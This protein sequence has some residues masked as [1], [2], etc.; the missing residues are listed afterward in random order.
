M[1]PCGQGAPSAPGCNLSK[2]EIK[3]AKEAFA[4]GMKEQKAKRLDEAFQSF[5]TAAQMAPRN[6]EYV[7]S[8]EI[9]R[10][11]LVFDDLQRGNAAML[12][13]N[14]MEALADFRGATLLDPQ[15]EFA[16][17]RVRDALGD[18]AP[19]TTAPP[20]ILRAAGELYVAPDPVR[21]DFHY[22]GDSRDLLEQ[23]AK[24]FGITP[25]LDDS[26]A[27]RNIRFDLT[28]VDF[29]SAMRVACAVTHT[30]WTPI[31]QKQILIAAE[32]PENHRRFDRMA[33]RTFYLPG[34]DTPAEFTA[35]A[36]ILRSLFDIKIVTAAPAEGTL[37]VNAPQ[38]LLDAATQFIESMDSSRPEVML[39][40]RVYQISSNLTRNL[41][42]QIPNQF[43]LFNIP[44]AALL[45]LGGGQNLQSLINQLIANG[46]INQ[47]N[48]TALSALL[49]QL[50]GQGQQNSIFSQPVATFGNGRTL[51]GVSLG[52]VG[53]QL[54]ANQSWVT[55][56]EH[57][58]L[59]VSQGTDTTFRVGSR[60]PIL[61]ASFAPIFNTP[62]IAQAIGNNSFQAPFPSF[63][64]E[65][66]GLSLKARALVSR[67]DDVSLSLEMQLRTLLGQSL[68]S[69]PIIG[70]R[71]FQGSLTLRDGEPAVIA[72]AVTRSET[73]S[74]TGIP[75][76]GL[77][78]GLNRIMTS[79]SQQGNEDELLVVVTPRVIHEAAQRQATVWLP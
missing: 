72:G 77:V 58:T 27:Q 37:T 74:M 9:V 5:Q 13:G 78:P 33:V 62:A 50:Q 60:Y 38:P 69:V 22:R 66:L 45:A 2:K 42:L 30:F 57:S 41:G 79:N 7:T 4:R 35:L 19:R 1:L 63:N 65:D 31:Q 75:G 10:Q 14:Q 3:E 8:R 48:S 68:N 32:S 52:T 18:Q 11:Q 29:F 71:E 20:R 23:V 6:V 40:V 43:N 26:V 12:K 55:S 53:A 67:N 61:N 51:T 70:N 47:A 49:S 64:Y 54:A 17:Q 21:A 59:R 39:D 46:G 76:L 16:Q 28:G 24:T 36:N 73:R 44:A 56:L 15:N 34:F 25:G